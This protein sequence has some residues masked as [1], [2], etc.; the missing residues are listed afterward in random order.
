VLEI[1]FGLQVMANGR[2][3]KAFEQAF[4]ALIHEDLEGRVLAFDAAAAE[5]AA[6]LAAAR[7]R[8]GRPIDFRDTEIAGIAVSRRAAIATRN[9]GH[10]E[11]LPLPIIDP[12]IA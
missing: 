7:Q 4:A 10:F 9:V 3:R 8:S 1:R 6:T 11:D 2:R 5:A 12:W